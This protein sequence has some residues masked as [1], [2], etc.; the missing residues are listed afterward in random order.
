[1]AS[2]DTETFLRAEKFIFAVS[3]PANR[4]FISNPVQFV[5]PL[6]FAFAYFHPY[7]VGRLDVRMRIFME[8]RFARNE[9]EII[10]I[11]LREINHF[12][13]GEIE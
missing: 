13:N 2:K 3:Y 7:G 8:I 12:A 1:M 9:A 5:A 4:I 6:C 10:V 11:E